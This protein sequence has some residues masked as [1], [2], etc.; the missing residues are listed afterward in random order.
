MPGFGLSSFGFD[1]ALG[2]EIMRDLRR[3]YAGFEE[4]VFRERKSVWWPLP[5][6]PCFSVS[7]L[8]GEK[9]C[10]VRVSTFATIYVAVRSLTKR[11]VAILQIPPHRYQCFKIST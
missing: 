6:S 10:F 3:D 1:A 8:G 2:S 11:G 5:F 9:F 4:E 7:H